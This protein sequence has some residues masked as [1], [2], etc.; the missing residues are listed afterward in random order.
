M[1]RALLAQ[2]L[3]HLLLGGLIT[4]LLVASSVVLPAAPAH[5]ADQYV[6]DFSISE[7]LSFKAS[8]Y[9]GEKEDMLGQT[10]ATDPKKLCEELKLD[11]N[12]M[13][14]NKLERDGEDEG[15]SS[16][17]VEDCRFIDSHVFLEYAGK[18]DEKLLEK[19]SSKTS[20][21]ITDEGALNVKPAWMGP[22]S[23]EEII[24]TH[25]LGLIRY[26]FPGKIKNVTP[27]IGKISG[28]TW[29]LEH[30][31]TNEQKEKVIE[32]WS[33][34]TITGERY[35]SKLGLILGITIPAAL[36]IVAV[37]V[38][39]IVRSKRKKKQQNLPPYPAG[40]ATYPPS[41]FMPGN[42]PHPVQS[43]TPGY[44][45]APGAP[46]IP[47]ATQ[48][49][50]H[51]PQPPR[52]GVAGISPG[53]PPMPGTTQPPMSRPPTQGGY[54]PQYGHF[55]TPPYPPN[56]PQG[57]PGAPMPGRCNPYPYPYP[58][59]NPQNPAGGQPPMMNQSYGY[60]APT[61][62]FPLPQTPSRSTQP[63]AAGAPEQPEQP[64]RSKHAAYSPQPGQSGEPGKP[65]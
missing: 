9:E 46:G 43:Q 48:P 8:V 56:V 38:L 24:K 14:N 32:S 18:W 63:G 11:R 10:D 5:A 31:S 53:Q 4:G 40:S 29:T 39:L 57:Q 51:A 44:P 41:P 2:R 33:Q 17:Q 13:I 50:R 28:N 19:A 15:L 35:S 34:L 12:R 16:L 36:I 47:R 30:P 1:K 6:I 27:N 37:I 23:S 64:S 60:G 49:P 55:P 7:D 52:P 25:D 45:A 62:G 54:P 3:P 61:P 22:I 42:S 58:P 26:V 20:P 65:V 59:A 21:I